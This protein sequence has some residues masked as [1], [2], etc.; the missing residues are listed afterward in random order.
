M[1]HFGQIRNTGGCLELPLGLC[2][3]I[4]APMTLSSLPDIELSVLNPMELTDYWERHEMRADPAGVVGTADR[5]CWL[6][7]IGRSGRAAS[8]PE[9]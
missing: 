1:I 4:A 2:P 6:S 7:L 5:H 3:T 8:L 9:W